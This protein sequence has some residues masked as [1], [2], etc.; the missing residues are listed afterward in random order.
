MQMAMRE[1]LPDSHAH[2]RSGTL[3][4]LGVA[5]DG[6]VAGTRVSECVCA[7]PMALRCLASKDPVCEAALRSRCLSA[8]CKLSNTPVVNRQRAVASRVALRTEAKVQGNVKK[9]RKRTPAEWLPL[10]RLPLFV[11]AARVAAQASGGALLRACIASLLVC[12]VVQGLGGVAAAS[13]ESPICCERSHGRW[14]W[15]TV[16]A[17]T[18][19][20]SSSGSRTPT[21]AR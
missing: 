9:V 16:V 4:P 18:R 19:P 8:R 2:P 1:D 21:S 10:W 15:R 14:Y 7:T 3:E 13:L 12:A 5:P 6:A 11:C 20:L 17:L